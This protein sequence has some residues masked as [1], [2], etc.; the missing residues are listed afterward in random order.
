MGALTSR[1]SNHTDVNSAFRLKNHF[2]FFRFGNTTDKLLCSKYFKLL[3]NGEIQTNIIIDRED[4]VEI[5]NRDSL[6]CWVNY[7][8]AQTTLT[9]LVTFNIQDI[10]DVVSTIFWSESSRAYSEY[11]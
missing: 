1:K 8:G 2:P 10:N 3:P 11:F 6:T 9:L 7:V 5:T 4:L